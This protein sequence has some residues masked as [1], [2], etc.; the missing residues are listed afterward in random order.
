[1]RHIACLCALAV[2]L[3]GCERSDSY[4]FERK[5]FERTEPQITIVLHRSLADLRAKAP[6]SA[7]SDPNRK[8]MAWSVIRPN[9]CE[10]H[11][12]DPAVSYQPEWIGHETAHCVWGRW[13]P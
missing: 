5:E 3:S 10:M 12:V 6:P 4:V 1:M 13:H 9:G 8:L 11:V 7:K 2:A